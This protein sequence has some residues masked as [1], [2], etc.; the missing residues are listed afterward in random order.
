MI[1]PKN[2]QT[3]VAGVDCGLEQLLR[4]DFEVRA[5]IPRR[6]ILQPHRRLDVLALTQ[7]S[8]AAFFRIRI[9]RVRSHLLPC[10]G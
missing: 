9:E 7:Q 6:R 4:A 8:A 2:L 5:A 3:E 10:G 1:Y